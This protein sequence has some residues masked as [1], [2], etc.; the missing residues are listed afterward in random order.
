M[1][2]GD[3]LDEKVSRQVEAAVSSADLVLLVVDA[4]VGTVSQDDEIAAW[5]RRSGVDV[6]VV[7]NKAD[8]DGRRRDVG[9][10]ALGLGEP[11][12]VSALHGRRAG[13]LLD[14]VLERLGDRASVREEEVA[15]WLEEEP[16]DIAPDTPQ[17]PSSD[18]RM[19]ASRRSLIGL[20]VRIDLLSMT[21]QV[22]PEMPLT[23]SFKP[24]MARSSLSIR[25]VC[26]AAKSRRQCGVL[27]NGRALRAIDEADIALMVIDGTEGVTAQI[28]GLPNVSMP[29]GVP[30]LCC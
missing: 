23:P 30:S 19:S 6:I 28:N 14:V 29:Q 10:L 8:N 9:F 18:A 7:A 21:C 27:L 1:P 5:L 11:V 25:Q 24:K 4:S 2:G 22:R 15:P 20:L 13:D 3:D 17:S 16:R 12:P 26:A